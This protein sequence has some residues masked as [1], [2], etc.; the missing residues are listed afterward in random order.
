MMDL[1]E[2]DEVLP[3]IEPELMRCP[4]PVMERRLR[5]AAIDM[6]EQTNLWLWRHP[7]V[8]VTAGECVY[9]LAA[10]ST[11]SEV[12]SVLELALEGMRLHD[13]SMQGLLDGQGAA[14]V[15]PCGFIVP[16]RGEIELLIKPMRS[17]GDVNEPTDRT[18]LETLVSLKPTRGAMTLPRVLVRDHY[19]ALVAG[20]L[21]RALRMRGYDWS[22]AKGAKRLQGEYELLVAGIKRQVDRGYTTK[23]TRVHPRKFA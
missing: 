23:S 7:E 3:D 10:P 14:R 15:R 2:I 22:E 8:P 9:T 4:V 19:D 5:E 11:E 20:T 16:H 12:H 6:C 1:I 17:T 21:Y 13:Y 18:G